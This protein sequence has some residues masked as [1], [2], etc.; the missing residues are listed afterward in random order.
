MQYLAQATIIV[1]ISYSMMGIIVLA[2]KIP[3]LQKGD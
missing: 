3:D 2:V 1:F